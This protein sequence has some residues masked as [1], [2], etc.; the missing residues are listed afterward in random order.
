MW[1][2]SPPG[3][4]AS[5]TAREC[6]NGIKDAGLRDRVL[7]AVQNF[8]A[9]ST[10]YQGA[11]LDN[12]VHSLS[13]DSYPVPGISGDEMQWLY[14]TQLAKRSRPARV[15]YDSI[16]QSAPNGLCC[17]CQYGKASTLDHFVPKTVIPALAV[18]PWNLVPCCMDC[19][20]TLLD[21][22]GCVPEEQLLHPYMMPDIGRWLHA[23][24]VE[25]LPPTVRFRV[26]PEDRLDGSLRSRIYNQV[27]A[28]RLNHLYAVVSTQDLCEVSINA[29]RIF[30][31]QGADGVHDHLEEMSQDYLSI[32]MN[33][34]RGVL[35]EALASSEWYCHGGFAME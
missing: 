15:I 12:L 23:E 2:V 26:E 6:V 9:N 31:L 3:H 7:G 14:S 13:N 17:Y 22:F 8:D 27:E 20:H 10:S 18:D 32:N 34:R 21:R 5:T 28:L 35:Y 29:S 30:P 1:E 4:T 33:S 24:V 19:N 25:G 11:I 16:I